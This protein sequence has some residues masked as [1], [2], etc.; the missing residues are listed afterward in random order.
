MF[1]QFDPVMTVREFLTNLG[2][3]AGTVS[4]VSTLL[5]VVA[6]AVVAWL[7]MIFTRVIIVRVFSAIVKRTR[8]PYDDKFLATKMFRNFA[9]IV[10]GV[11]VWQMASLMLRENPGWLSFVHKS[12]ALYIVVFVTLTLSSFIEGWHQVWL[13]HPISRGRSIKP[14]VQVAK[15][16]IVFTGILAAVSVLFKMSLVNV[17]TG[18]GVATAVLALIFKDTILGLVASVQL[19]GNNMVRL[20]DWIT[21]PGRNVDG[22]VIDMTLYTVKV[23]NFDKTILTVPTYALVSESFQNW[24]G[25]ED[26]GVRRIKREI[27]IDVRSISFL[28]PELLEEIGR[29]PLTAGWIEAH[30]DSIEAVER[31]E[32]TSLTNLHAFRA[33]M[34]EYLRNH[35]NIDTR[36]PIMVR[37]M[38]STEAGL[39]V[40]IY[41]FSKIH[42]WVP[43]EGVQSDVIDYTFAV[44]GRFGLRPYQS[45][46]GSDLEILKPHR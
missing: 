35:I 3:S 18:L 42:S 1:R 14:Y 32:S 21:I 8:S 34:V 43:F 38:P 22:T 16:L 39:P 2:L 10:P 17:V 12:S 31:G 27:R 30:R 29:L 25:M 37:D 26:A 15:V 6:V 45:P 33:Y 13:S 28:T 36:M 20:G 40:E 41:C 11:V 46:A 23:E 24:R 44:V 9:L 5:L 7:S 4:W 19:S